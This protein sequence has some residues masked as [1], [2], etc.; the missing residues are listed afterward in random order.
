MELEQIIREIFL[1]TLEEGGKELSGEL[2][3][4][5]I[6][7][8]T[9]MDSLGFATVVAKL[10]NEIGYD[11]FTLMTTPF[12][13]KTYGEFIGIYRKFENHRKEP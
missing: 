10:D 1:E 4:D 6:L 11:P 13:P 2:V 9:G 8:D 5:S 3:D 12:Y 7:L